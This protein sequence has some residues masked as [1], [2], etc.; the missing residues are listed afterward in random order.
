MRFFQSVGVIAIFC[1]WCVPLLGQAP[2]LELTLRYNPTLTRYEVYA[3]PDASQSVF[4][5]G[6]AQ[7]S[8]VVPE[9]VDN[10]AFAVTS[11][12]GGAWQDNSRVYAPA[13]DPAHDFHGVGS[14]GAITNLMQGVEK[15][16]FHFT[17][18]GGGCVSGLRL[19]EN[20][21]DPD[22]SQPGMSGGDFS[23]TIFAIVQGVPQGYE[24]YTVNYDNSGTA[25]A[26]LPLELTAFKAISQTASI[27]LE[28]KTAN[29]LNFDRFELERSINALN[30]TAVAQ[31]E[32][33]G[34]TTVTGTGEYAYTDISVRPGISY[35]YRLKMVDDDGFFIY[36][37]LQQAQTDH[38]GYSI[39]SISPNPTL[40]VTHLVYHAS[41]DGPV[42][43][44]LTDMAGQVLETRT[45]HSV[46]GDNTYKIDLKRYAPGVYWLSLKT[47]TD[48]VSAKVI[49]AE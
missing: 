14:L 23:N 18:P 11:V 24:A 20:A 41:A 25:C 8:I 33:H 19:F 48:Q 29:E 40:D 6:P 26:P 49:R 16:I 39:G 7:I 13:A 37:N 12:A 10:A 36:S 44:D 1:G 28:W 27:G 42:T 5:W 31:I 17:I 43:L 30:F 2:N 15:L 9:N 45:F 4:N 3:L 38:T 34:K 46:K 35:Y 32:P 21:S 47:D 22:S